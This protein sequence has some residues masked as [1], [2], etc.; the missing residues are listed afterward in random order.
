[1]INSK[2]AA[3]SCN[4]QNQISPSENHPTP[5]GKRQDS[6][7]NAVFSEVLA[8]DLSNSFSS[9]VPMN[10]RFSPR[11]VGLSVVPLLLGLTL[12]QATPAPLCDP[13]NGGLV[14]PKGA[15]A[16][17]VASNVGSVRQLTVSQAGDLYA[18]IASGSHGV[19]A[20][21]DID[22]DGKPDQRA[23]FAPGGANDVE[24]RNGFLYVSFKDRILR[25]RIVPG[26]LK[27]SG[28]AEVVVS[29]LPGSSGHKAKSLAF[30]LSGEMYV[31]V[32]SATNSCQQED[33]QEH[34]PGK[35]PCTELGHRAGIWQFSADRVGQ[36]FEDGQRYATGLRNP[37]ALITH[38]GGKKLYA[39]VHGR[40]Q[41]GDNWGFSPEVNA[42]NP[43]EELVEIESGDTSAGPTATTATNTRR[44]CWPRSTEATD[45]RLADVP[46]P[47]IRC[48]RFPGTGLPWPSPSTT[49]ISSGPSIEV[50]SL[51]P[52]MVPGI[53]PP[54]HKQDI[55]SSSFPSAVTNRAAPTRPSQSRGMAPRH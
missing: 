6:R 7:G 16:R 53:E 34:S 13:D 24:L 44:R 10:G 51:S 32:G 19:L 26:Q 46:P 37:L 54:Y 33:R 47:R 9:G 29:G 45:K 23:N 42:D 3:P 2:Q 14:L 27:P 40:D 12:R 36:R 48:W 18:A 55:A 15:C 35:D 1:V 11:T 20:L 17:V 22:G 5:L 52:S 30:G 39:A 43:A 41:L 38:D 50:A 31:S 28:D 25:Y 49:P 21:R 8:G 4:R